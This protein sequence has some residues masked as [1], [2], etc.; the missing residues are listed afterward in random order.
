M[1]AAVDACRNLAFGVGALSAGVVVTFAGPRLVYGLVGVG[2]LI[3]CV[4]IAALVRR[5]GGL[6]SLRARG[7]AIVAA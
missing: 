5:L 6:R 3:G 7:P 1:L 2:V 4:P